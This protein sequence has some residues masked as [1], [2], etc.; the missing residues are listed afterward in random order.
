MKKPVAKKQTIEIFDWGDS[1]TM[2][3]NDWKKLLSWFKRN[4]I[5]LEFGPWGWRRG[6]K[7]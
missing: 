5:K 2:S 1:V 7:R 6:A 4:G 3:K